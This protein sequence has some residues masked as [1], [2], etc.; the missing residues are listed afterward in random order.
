MSSL[1]F[2]SHSG[3]NLAAV[4]AKILNEFCIAEKV[5]ALEVIWFKTYAYPYRI[6]A[7]ESPAIVPLI[8]IP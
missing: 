2:K 6:S 4:F 3:V 8:T 7:W 1:L 5:R